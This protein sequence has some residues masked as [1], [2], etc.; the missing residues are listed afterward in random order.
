MSD[1]IQNPEAYFRQF[2]PA[3]DVL[4]QELEDEA[5]R[6]DIPIVGP[7]VG[8]LLYILAR[9]TQ[10]GRILE[11]GT[12][13]GY[14]TIYFARA[15]ETH[16]GRVVTLEIDRDMAHRALANIKK[17]G[18]EHLVENRAGDALKEMAA[19]QGPFDLIF[20]D[21]E[22]ADYIR[23][24]PD[25]GR[26]LRNGG[27]LV[28]DNTGFKDADEFNRAIMND[29]RWRAVNLLALLPLHSPEQD[30]LCLALRT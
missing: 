17:A 30:G 18:L 15:C 12:A 14:S 27:L 25:C 6:E 28:A 10:A 9:T 1:M 20:L 22:K 24:L 19:L 26:L 3:R 16:Q 2:V 29:P 8:E 13:T 23:V 21:I 11:L 5:R 4:L 7:V